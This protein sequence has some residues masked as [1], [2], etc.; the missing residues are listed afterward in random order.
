MS[1]RGALGN[2]VTS[3]A[4]Q[5]NDEML[6]RVEEHLEAAGVSQPIPRVVQIGGEPIERDVR[7]IAG[8]DAAIEKSRQRSLRKHVQVAVTEVMSLLDEVPSDVL[9]ALDA[10]FVDIAR[11]LVNAALDDV[12]RDVHN[13]LR[14]LAAVHP[15]SH[16][17]PTK[18]NP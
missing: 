15:V 13:K 1:D 2:F 4:E 14:T 16:S 18:E 6:D 3:H 9:V 10:K 8:A 5:I 17:H 7:L 11:S 12:S